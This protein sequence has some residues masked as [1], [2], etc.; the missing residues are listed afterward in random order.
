MFGNVCRKRREGDRVKKR[1]SFQFPA[2]APPFVTASRRA[3]NPSTT[4][5][6]PEKMKIKGEK[7]EHDVRERKEE[8]ENKEENERKECPLILC[9]GVHAVMCTLTFLATRCLIQWS[10]LTQE[11][12]CSDIHNFT[13]TH[14]NYLKAPSGS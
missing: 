11:N 4:L 2:V 5:L 3:G 12:C 6:L 1:V 10:A 13:I 8:R 7:K 14:G 9:A